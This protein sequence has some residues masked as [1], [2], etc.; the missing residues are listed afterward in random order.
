MSFKKQ[1]KVID[2]LKKQRLHLE[3]ARVLSFTE[4]EFVRILEIGDKL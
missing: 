1:A 2:I 4:D 3:A